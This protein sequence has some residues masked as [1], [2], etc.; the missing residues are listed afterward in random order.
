LKKTQ[1]RPFKEIEYFLFQLLY[2]PDTTAVPYVKSS[3]TAMCN[4]KKQTLT[5]LR[6][7]E[8]FIIMYEINTVMPLSEVSTN[9]HLT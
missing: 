4:G 2:E 6:T 8:C 1:L 7:V 3:A 9:T 5:S